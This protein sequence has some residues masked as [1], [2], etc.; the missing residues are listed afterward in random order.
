MIVIVLQ[1]EDVAYIVVQMCRLCFPRAIGDRVNIN[2]QYGILHGHNG[3][4][5]GFFLHLAA[6][7]IPQ[8]GAAIGTYAG[9]G[10]IAVAFFRNKA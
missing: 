7:H 1:A 9:P 5:T 8:I 3:L 10:A 4:Q 2:I 6:C